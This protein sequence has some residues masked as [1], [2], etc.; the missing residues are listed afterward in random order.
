MKKGKKVQRRVLRTEWGRG[1]CTPSL[2]V[3]NRPEKVSTLQ[4]KEHPSFDRNFLPV[5]GIKRVT[6][7]LRTRL[8]IINRVWNFDS[9]HDRN[10]ISFKAKRK[11]KVRRSRNFTVYVGFKFFSRTLLHVEYP[12]SLS[13]SFSFSLWLFFL[14][15]PFSFLLAFPPFGR[16]FPFFSFSL[17]RIASH[18]IA[19]HE[20][21]T[22]ISSERTFAR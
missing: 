18:R 5:S 7:S 13:L 17:S 12:I 6:A 15:L 22:Y 20:N 9:T 8:I 3:L 4:V 16:L 1:F 14:H 21:P 19:S 11:R 2:T 10:G